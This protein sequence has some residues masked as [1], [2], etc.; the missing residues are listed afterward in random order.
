MITKIFRMT[1]VS[2]G[3]VLILIAALFIGS[4]YYYRYSQEEHIRDRAVKH[5]LKS[6]RYK[7]LSHFTSDEELDRSFRIAKIIWENDM[8]V[9]AY[10]G[11]TMG[12]KTF[13]NNKFRIIRMKDEWI[14]VGHN[15]PLSK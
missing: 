6:D 2:T 11:F 14:V 7:N 4:K 9:V 5:Y 3:V 12:G 1:I 10:G 15:N 13:K 8:S